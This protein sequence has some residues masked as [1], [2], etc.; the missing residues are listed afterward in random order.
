MKIATRGTTL[1][2]FAAVGIILASAVT[3]T[4]ASWGG[5]NGH[6]E[7]AKKPPAACPDVAKPA[8]PGATVLS[9]TTVEKP[10]GGSVPF[11]N[12]PGY[13]TQP[14]TDVPAH[15]QVSV[16]LT[17]PGDGDRVLVEIWLPTQSWTGRFQGTGGGGFAAASG[18]TALAQAIKLGYSAGYTDAGHDLNATDPK[19]WALDAHGEVN[20]ALFTNFASRSVHDIKS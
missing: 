4:P 1:K 8:V 18:D 13:P 19:T 10:D 17:H 9:L 2:L 15:C 20:K 7:V 5:Q 14:I 6:P 12:I 3:F 16:T 11:P